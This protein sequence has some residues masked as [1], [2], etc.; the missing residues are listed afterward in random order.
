M[1]HHMRNCYTSHL[2]EPTDQPTISI[3]QGFPNNVT[4]IKAMRNFMFFMEL[5]KSALYHKTFYPEMAI[6]RPHLND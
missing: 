3:I 6:S 4:V 5:D 2:P 1:A